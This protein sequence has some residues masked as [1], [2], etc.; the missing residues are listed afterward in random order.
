[1]FGYY[2]ESMQ[3]IPMGT[4]A[5]MCPPAR[6]EGRSCLQVCVST[7]QGHKC[8]CSE[9]VSCLVAAARKSVT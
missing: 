1:M 6:V 9:A 7:N 3:N 8:C 4:H 2:P 5:H